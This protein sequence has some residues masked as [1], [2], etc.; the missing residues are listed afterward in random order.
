MLH[1]LHSHSRLSHASDSG[2]VA[3]TNRCVISSF[4]ICICKSIII[5][6]SVTFTHEPPTASLDEVPSWSRVDP[7]SNIFDWIA[8]S[9]AERQ[10][11]STL[12]K[13]NVNLTPNLS[14]LRLYLTILHSVTWAELASVVSTTPQLQPSYSMQCDNRWV[15]LRPNAQLAHNCK[16]GSFFLWATQFLF[17][18]LTNFF[19]F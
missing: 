11:Q 6:T 4:C 1:R 7:S 3:W 5:T 14:T 17:L 15:A 13:Y 12:N 10:Q 9:S 18:V 8:V 19:R 2:H 16:A